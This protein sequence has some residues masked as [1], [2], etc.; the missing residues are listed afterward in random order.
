MPRDRLLILGG[1]RDA[2]EIADVLVASGRNVVTSL[3]GVTAQPLLPAGEVRVGG[4]GGVA[5]LKSYL[6]TAQI[7]LVIDATHPFAARMSAQAVAAC[8]DCRV[9]LLRFERPPWTARAGDDWRIVDSATQAASVLPRG[10]RVLLTTGRKDLDPFFARSDIS[11]IARMIE[12]PPLNPPSNWKILRERPPFTVP[13]EMA[14]ISDNAITHLV[15]KNAGGRATEAKL[16]AAREL[17]I[18]VVM[19]AR[20]VKPDAPC[21][22]AMDNLLAVVEGVLCP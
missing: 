9:P 8:D 2:R 6:E 14:L 12:E 10:A 18:P 5:G 22:A 20:P 21:V 1:T 19:I 16:H 15:T 4:F 11:G 3:A 17:R 7:A 13:D